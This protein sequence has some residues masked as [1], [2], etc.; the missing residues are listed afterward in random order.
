[1]KENISLGLAYRFRDSTHY[2]QGGKHG[3]IQT[4]FYI[5]IQRLFHR[6]PGE[7]SLLH[8][9]ELEHRRRPQRLW[10]T[11]FN[12]AAPSPT[13]P[14]LLKVT[15]TMGQAYSNH[16]SIS[17]LLSN[18]LNINVIH[19]IVT[20]LICFPTKT[21]LNSAR[22]FCLFVKCLVLCVCVLFLFFFSVINFNYRNGKIK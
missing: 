12:K 9:E 15:L 18:E 3:S 7:G 17:L 8:W 1:M 13:G 6:W 11:P 20:A 5:L 21:S 19:I 16:Y 14:C 10:H 4:D 22:I 2:C